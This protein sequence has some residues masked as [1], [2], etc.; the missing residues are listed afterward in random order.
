M[1]LESSFFSKFPKFHFWRT[2][3]LSLW[4]GITSGLIPAEIRPA[5]KIYKWSYF[6]TREQFRKYW[7]TRDKCRWRNSKKPVKLFRCRFRFL[8][9]TSVKQIVPHKSFQNWNVHAQLFV[10]RGKNN[11]EHSCYNISLFGNGVFFH[12]NVIKYFCV[13]TNNTYTLFKL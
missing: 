2:I 5:V 6:Q 12:R 11:T 1:S 7:V 13:F 4:R 8:K 9:T 3:N 10:L